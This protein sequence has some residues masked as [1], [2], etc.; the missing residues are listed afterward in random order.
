MLLNCGVVEVHALFVGVRPIVVAQTSTT[1]GEP[2]GLHG[3]PAG[4]LRW[5]QAAAP[6]GG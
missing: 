5:Q 2:T 1:R 6:L 4:E 3:R